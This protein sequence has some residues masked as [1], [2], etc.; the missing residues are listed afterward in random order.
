MIRKM[1]IADLDR[2]YTIE[3]QSFFEPWSKKKLLKDL[4]HNSFLKHYV[5]EENGEILG[6][7]IFSYILD[8]VEIFTIAV[9]KDMRSRGIGSRLLDFLLDWCSRNDVGE[10]WLEVATKNMS[11]IGLYKKYGFSIQQVRKNYYQKTG[12][13]AYNM[14]RKLK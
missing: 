12:E 9:D 10:I 7:L 14:I 2:V 1:E 5:Y 3:N 4:E 11:A 13:D 8:L 6:F